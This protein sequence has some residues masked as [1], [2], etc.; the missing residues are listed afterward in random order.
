MGSQPVNGTRLDELG[1]PVWTVLYS[2]GWSGP[3]NSVELFL[4]AHIEFVL[5]N[6]NV[7]DRRAKF[8]FPQASN[9]STHEKSGR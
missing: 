8:R 6:G 7:Y 9:S 4:S 2:A 5:A 3:F 1:I